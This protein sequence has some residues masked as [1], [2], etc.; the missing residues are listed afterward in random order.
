MPRRK[1]ACIGGYVYHVL[2]RSVGKKQIFTDVGDYDAFEQVLH[3]ATERVPVRLLSHCVMPN[4]WHLVLWPARGRDN[5][6]SEFMQWMTVTHTQRWHS[7]HGTSGTGPLYQGRFKSFPVQGDHHFLTVCRYVERNALRACLV[8]R[9]QDWRWCSLWH[10]D[11]ASSILKFSNW[12][13]PCPRHWKQLVNT[14]QNEAEL[15]AVRRSVNR[16]CPFG[17][18]TWVAKTAERLDLEPTLRPRGRPRK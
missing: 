10:R 15:N 16:G 7:F 13:V 2:N 14:P 8:E 6:V 3:E 9:A 18:D 5:D 12:P 11:Q 4:H 17:D 1:R